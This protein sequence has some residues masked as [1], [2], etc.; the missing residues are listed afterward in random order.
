MLLNSL[1]F[2]QTIGIFYL[3]IIPTNMRQ[4]SLF[5]T[6]LVFVFIFILMVGF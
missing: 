3:I 2:I 5:I 6:S 1:F 4:F